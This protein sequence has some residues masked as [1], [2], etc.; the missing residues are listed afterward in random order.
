MQPEKRFRAGG[1]AA[2]V[3]MHQTVRNGQPTVY[4]SVNFDK[5]YKDK[6]GNWKS[7]TNLNVAD[8]PKAIMVLGKA[9]EHLAMKQEDGVRKENTQESARRETDVYGSARVSPNALGAQGQTLV[10]E[11]SPIRQERAIPSSSQAQ[12]F[13]GQSLAVTSDGRR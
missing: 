1:I 13:Y 8:I 11:A 7:T 6:D 5:R 9:Y 12:G 2:T 4:P 3:W 10:S